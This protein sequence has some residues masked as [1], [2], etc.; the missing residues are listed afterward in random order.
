MLL[1]QPAVWS[2]GHGLLA[3]AAAAFLVSF[4]GCAQSGGI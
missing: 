1:K 4:G 3:L 2:G